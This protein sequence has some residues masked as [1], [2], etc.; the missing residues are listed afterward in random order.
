MFVSK[1][2]NDSGECECFLL[3]LFG[4]RI[5][6]DCPLDETYLSQYLVSTP[7]SSSLPY[8]KSQWGGLQRQATIASGAGGGLMRT[9]NLVRCQLFPFESRAFSL[10]SPT[11][12]QSPSHSCI[13]FLLFC[14]AV[15]PLSLSRAYLSSLFTFFVVH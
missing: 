9:P 6:L 1:L 12:S 7:L 8:S 4:S 3:D 14:F 2:G 15:K 11:H 5:L 10:R 13:S